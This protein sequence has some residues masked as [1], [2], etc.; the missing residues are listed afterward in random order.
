MIWI[1]LSEALDNMLLYIEDQNREKE[2]QAFERFRTVVVQAAVHSAFL[3]PE[4]LE[5][6]SHTVCIGAYTV[7]V[8]EIS[9]I[10]W[11]SFP[12]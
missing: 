4:Q 1:P 11:H 12:S 2:P 7:A 9:R 6:P 3:A 10:L 8:R 5:E